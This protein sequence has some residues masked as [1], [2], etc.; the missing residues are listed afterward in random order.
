[1]TETEL[2]AA[3]TVAAFRK[4][5]KRTRQFQSLDSAAWE[6]ARNKE[7]FEEAVMAYHYALIEAIFT[8]LEA[9]EKP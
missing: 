8:M 4:A 5:Q 1:M 6:K 9:N 2:D 3:E 7:T